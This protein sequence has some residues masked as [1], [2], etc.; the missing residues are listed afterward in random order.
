MPINLREMDQIRKF[1]QGLEIDHEEYLRALEVIEYVFLHRPKP[2]PNPQDVLT[3]GLY[4]PPFRWLTH[5][6]IWPMVTGEL[7]G[8]VVWLSIV[9]LG[10]YLSTWPKDYSSVLDRLAGDS[11]GYLSALFELEVHHQFSERGF[12]LDSPPESAGMDFLF[13]RDDLVLYVEATHRGSAIH[14]QKKDEILGRL[15]RLERPIA[16]EPRNTQILVKESYLKNANSTMINEIASWIACAES[17]E[18]GEEWE[19]PQG[20]CRINSQK[21]VNG[22][23]KTEFLWH[24]AES[25]GQL[26]VFDAGVLMKRQLTDSQKIK[27]L[28]L[29]T[30][31]IMAVDVRSLLLRPCRRAN[32]DNFAISRKIMNE[33]LSSTQE[34]LNK[35]NHLQ[36][37]LLW[38]PSLMTEGTEYL[39]HLSDDVLY[40]PAPAPRGTN[41][42]YEVGVNP[43]EIDWLT[44]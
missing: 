35:H 40:V 6:P 25:E 16:E 10:R 32:R 1:L 36:G 2:S 14:W 23:G 22:S 9:R 29:K 13:R 38:I 27:Q 44:S 33:I 18:L 11:S 42:G 21:S 39:Y 15:M 5:N 26:A 30:P 31:S 24:N 17:G 12:A 4:P 19:E 7:G 20:R 37:V 34:V 3:L 8:S 41:A 43:S 28:S